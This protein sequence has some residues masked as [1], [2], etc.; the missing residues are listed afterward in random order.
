MSLLGLG[1][2]VF[3]TQNKYG[4]EIFCHKLLLEIAMSLKLKIKINSRMFKFKFCLHK[5]QKWSSQAKM[6][7]WKIKY[8]SKWMLKMHKITNKNLNCNFQQA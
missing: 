5:M 3:Y 1:N 2:D 8:W 7:C 4:N 6:L